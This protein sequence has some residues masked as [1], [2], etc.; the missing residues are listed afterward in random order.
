MIF[1]KAANSQLTERPPV[2]M[3]RQA[4]R[5]MKEY[6]DFKKR[7]KEVEI[8]VSSQR[9]TIAGKNN[10]YQTRRG[11]SGNGKG[12]VPKCFGWKWCSESNR[13]VEFACVPKNRK[14]VVSK[15]CSR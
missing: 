9:K 8:S 15:I 1:L 13:L 4:G 7:H 11:G 12:R 10:R 3:M 14:G 6:W 5:F 2:W